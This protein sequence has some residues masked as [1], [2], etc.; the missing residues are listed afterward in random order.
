MIVYRDAA[1][2]ARQ[3]LDLWPE[4]EEPV[5]R[6]TALEGYAACAELAGDFD[7]GWV[8]GLAEGCSTFSVL[9]DT[10]G[11]TPPPG[12]GPPPSSPQFTRLRCSRRPELCS[13]RRPARRP[14]GAGAALK[15]VGNLP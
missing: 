13:G 8:G 3:A 12:P 5:L 11:R 10:K 9:C 4:G 2:A 15:R 7:T 6:A 1:R 14:Q